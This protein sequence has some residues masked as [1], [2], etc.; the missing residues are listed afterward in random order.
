[1]KTLSL[2][3]S[4]AVACLALLPAQSHAAELTLPR[5]GW[6]S[7]QVDAV[8]GAPEW[9]C[10]SSWDDRVA[11][12]ETCKLDGERQGYGTRGKATTD[13]LRIY[14]RLA[15]GKVERLRAM[16]ARCP[17]EAKTPIHEL[18]RVAADDSTRWLVGLTRKDTDSDLSGEGDNDVLPALAMHRGD[19]AQQALATMARDD[20]STER[21]KHAVFWLAM[22]RGVAGAEITTSV[23]FNDQDSEVRKHA[24]FAITESKSPHVATDLIRLG[25]TDKN[26]DVRSQAWFWLAHT[27]AAQSEDAIVAALR[28]DADDRVREEAVFALSQLPGER[29]TRA[30]IAVAEDRSL[31]NEQRKRAM[32]W[33]AQSESA[34]AHA[35]LDKVLAGN[36]AGPKR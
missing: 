20:A 30:L 25:N 12:R 13:S 7:W 16:S 32:F 36:S 10:W 33:L 26:N 8:E 15:G 17:V 27:G 14:A 21:R 24:A 34:G 22:L 28:K 18:G 5:D 1:M 4:S 35:F 3:I 6:T 9:C 29:A 23:M 11:T 19:L 2:T 31:S